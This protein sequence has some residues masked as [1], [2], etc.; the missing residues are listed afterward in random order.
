MRTL[1]FGKAA[2]GPFLFL[3]ASMLLRALTCWA[4]YFDDFPMALR[5]A[6]SA[7]TMAAAKAMLNLLELEFSAEKCKPFANKAEVLDVLIDIQENLI[8]TIRPGLDL[9]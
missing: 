8:F 4:V 9:G 6:T 5:D 7:S 2:R 1:L 3:R